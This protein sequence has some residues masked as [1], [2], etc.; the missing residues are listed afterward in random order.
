VGAALID[1]G[2]LLVGAAATRSATVH[3]DRGWSAGIAG[4]GIGAIA[5]SI[6]V[7]FAAD[8]QL[9]RA[10]FEFNRRFAR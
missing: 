2:M 5:T 6:P 8:A 7:Q 10:V 9:S 4:V 1:G 3:G